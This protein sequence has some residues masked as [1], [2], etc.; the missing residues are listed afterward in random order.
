M[1]LLFRIV[2]S[3]ATHSF[4]GKEPTDRLSPPGWQGNPWG[5]EATK[6]RS[7]GKLPQ[8]PYTP[9][10]KKWDA[11]GRKTLRDGD[12]IFRRGDA[13]VL[14]GYYPFSRFIAN[15]SGSR[16]SHVGTVVVEQGE[17]VVY[18]T[19]KA[20]VRRQPFPV[21]VL[22]NV[23]GI[24]VKR[25]K[26]D[27]RSHIPGIVAYLHRVYAEQV[28]FD[29]DLALDDKALYCVEMAEKAFR[30]EGLKL[31]DPVKVGDMEHAAEFPISIFTFHYLSKLSLSQ[32]LTLE[33][34]VFFPGNERHG[35][36]SSPLLETVY[37]A[38]SAKAGAGA[39]PKAMVGERPKASSR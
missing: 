15:C 5:P 12:V 36:W 35:I 29:Y 11:W 39:S 10:M 23:T 8:I 17:P 31:S 9:A 28:P 26:A 4:D 25:L 34:E 32:P 30:S 6:A 14:F 37:P 38:P 20:G 18:D 22:D 7:E 2:L 21:W 33:T 24:G 27:R 3:L 19:T 1:P 13:K 16:Y